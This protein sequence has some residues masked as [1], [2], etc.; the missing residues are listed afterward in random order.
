[1]L[2]ERAISLMFESALAA[3]DD[4]SIELLRR[5]IEIDP[6]NEEAVQALLQ[7]LVARGRESEAARTYQRFAARLEK[8]TGLK[9]QDLTT[10]IAAFR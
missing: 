1:M 7:M 8:E 3:Q 2:R 6:L 10:S 4:A 9:P 5:L